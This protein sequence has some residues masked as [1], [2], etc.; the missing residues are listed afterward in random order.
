MKSSE[1]D[2]V[3][4]GDKSRLYWYLAWVLL[5]AAVPV[6]MIFFTGYGALADDVND[7]MLARWV[8]DTGLNPQISHCYRVMHVLP[9]SLFYWIMGES[10]F[11][12]AMPILFFAL[13]THAMSILLARDTFGNR[14][15]FLTSLLF[16]SSPYETM[17]STMGVPDYII[18]CFCTACAWFCYRGV[19]RRHWLYMILGA[20]CFTGALLTKTS[21][22]GFLMVISAATVLW[23][24][25]WRQWAFFWGSMLL[26]VGAIC[27]ADYFYSEHFFR[28][29]WFN[30][31]FHGADVSDRLRQVWMALPKY[32]F[33]K[34]EYGTWM[35][36]ITGWIAMAGVLA[37]VVC[38]IMKKARA[39]ASV[40]LLGFLML[41]II[42]FMPHKLTL[43]GYYSHWRV[44]RY[45]AYVVPAIYLPAAF[46][47]E[48]L[49]RMKPRRVWTSLAVVL[50][51]IVVG[52][53]AYQTPRVTRAS[54]DAMR[55]G[56]ALIKY[57]KN[58]PPPQG[59]TIHADQWKCDRLKTMWHPQVTTHKLDHH[60]HYPPTPEERQ[61]V[62]G[63]IE[64]AIVITGGAGL[65][66]YGSLGYILNLVD[67]QFDPPAN[68]ELLFER[69]AQEEVWRREPMRVW[70]VV[71]R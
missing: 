62:L 8:L 52:I 33:H 37:A 7:A 64:D 40:I 11:A 58:N 39:G 12:F 25:R 63:S 65:A 4:K 19:T 1:P 70:R 10:T 44:F 61:K 47:I 24:T 30:N 5:L 60:S 53:N 67:A 6:R 20:L 56:R 46:F 31:F 28:W 21:A 22:L 45:L 34:S 9:R 2:E 23:I 42:E 59:L 51:V 26:L 66:W 38:L 41:L 50:L 55:D 49:F 35:F 16:L 32:L 3:V 36:G 17:C 54:C 15:A 69:E 48:M 29:Y 71:S 27:V 14:G 68:W 13:G 57:L 43:K 18:A